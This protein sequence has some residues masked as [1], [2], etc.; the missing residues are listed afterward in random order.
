M[1][2]DITDI[3]RDRRQPQRTRRNTKELPQRGKPQPKETSTTEAR[4]HGDTEK[5]QK[6]QSPNLNSMPFSPL[7][8]P[9]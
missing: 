2:A 9:S 5:N 1:I 3:A 7:V 8:T 6:E 4:R